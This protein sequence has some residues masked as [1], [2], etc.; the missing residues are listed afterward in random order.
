MFKQQLAFD[1][2]LVINNGALYLN[3]FSLCKNG[4]GSQ[5]LSALPL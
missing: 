3:L 4:E 2:F 5:I 1:I